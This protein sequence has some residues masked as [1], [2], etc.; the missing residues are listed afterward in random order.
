VRRGEVLG[1][2]ARR[3][4]VYVSQIKAWNGLRSDNIYVG[5]RLRV[6]A[7][8][9]GSAVAKSETATAP[10][11]SSTPQNTGTSTASASHHVV[12]SGDTLSEI[13][14]KYGIGLSELRQLN[15]LSGNNIRVG[16]RL[17]LRGTAGGSTSAGKTSVAAA[18]TYVVKSGDSLWVIA[19]KVGVP[20]EDLKRLNGLTSNALQVGQRL[21]LR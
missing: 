13:A 4:R 10:A 12:K 1:S 3:H 2:I 17:K 15:G 21:K 20:V 8:S 9:G 5:Q 16:Q 18:G 19:K 7:S 11:A 14:A 6:R